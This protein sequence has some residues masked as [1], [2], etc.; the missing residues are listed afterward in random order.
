MVDEVIANVSR[1]FAFSAAGFVEYRPEGIDWYSAG[2]RPIWKVT[3]LVAL[4]LELGTDY[5]EPE[6]GDARTLHKLT[7]AVALKPGHKF[8]A[9][10][11][12]RAFVTVA[13]WDEDARDAEPMGLYPDKADTRETTVGIQIEHFW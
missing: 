5:V 7:G 11:E 8:M 3:E 2:V 1:R 10:P 12:L 13:D 6:H 9:R 4:E